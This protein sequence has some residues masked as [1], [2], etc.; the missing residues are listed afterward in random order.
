MKTLNQEQIKELFSLK[1]TIQKL[2]GDIRTSQKLV[3][4]HSNKVRGWAQLKS[5]L[6]SKL[7]SKID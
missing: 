2:E 4:V 1:L 6:V 3:R 5:Q 7:L